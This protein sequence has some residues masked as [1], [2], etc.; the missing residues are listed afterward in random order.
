MLEAHTAAV[1]GPGTDISILT[2]SAL[3]RRVKRL[4]TGFYNDEGECDEAQQ[5]K[6]SGVQS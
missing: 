5:T 2:R 6:A 3:Q 4:G 1:C